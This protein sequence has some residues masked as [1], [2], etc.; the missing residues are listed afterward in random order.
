MHRTGQRSLFCRKPSI[1]AAETDERPELPEPEVEANAFAAALL[2]PAHLIRERYE[3]CSGEQNRFEQ[4][5]EEF[6]SSGAAM[7]RRLR[8]VI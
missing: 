7:S 8:A 4:M 2:M 3:E 6:D 5:C 1:E